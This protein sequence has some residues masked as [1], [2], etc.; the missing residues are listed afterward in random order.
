MYDGDETNRGVF[1]SIESLV[2]PW[3]PN[4]L[5]KPK[6]TERSRFFGFHGF[7]GYMSIVVYRSEGIGLSA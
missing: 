3:L 4:R 7:S 5:S 1:D 2:T 6:L